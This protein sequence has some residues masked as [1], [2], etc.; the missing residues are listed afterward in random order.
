MTP[1]DRRKLIE[2]PFPIV[3]VSA[4]KSWAGSIGV[5]TTEEILFRYKRQRMVDGGEE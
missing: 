4:G 5:D 2:T 1:E 3:R